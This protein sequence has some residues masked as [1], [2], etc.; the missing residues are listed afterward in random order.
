[1]QII[2]L[3]LLGVIVVAILYMV[4]FVKAPT[5]DEIVL[6]SGSKSG[7]TD[8]TVPTSIPLSLNQPEGITFSYTGWLLINDFTTGYGRVRKI[9]TKGDCPSLA[10]DSTSNSLIVSV[11]TYSTTETVLIPNIPASKWIHFGIVVNQNA[12]DIYINGTLRQH[13][14]LSQ[15]PDQT[16]DSVMAPRGWNGVLGNLSY[17]PRSLTNAEIRALSQ[18]K[19]PPDMRP[20]IG[21]PDY[22]DLS[23]YTGRL[24]SSA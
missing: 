5:S 7:S 21:V 8:I 6:I 19:P 10:I 2:G 15:L 23:W 11:K 9:F 16:T 20:S 24:N 22:F 3:L 13:H 14:S 1:M 18:Q 12:V 4:W 17:W